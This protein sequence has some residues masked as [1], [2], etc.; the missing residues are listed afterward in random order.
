MCCVVHPGAVHL[1]GISAALRL[2]LGYILGMSR[3][4][5]GSISRLEGPDQTLHLRHVLDQPRLLH[6]RR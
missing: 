6:L 4:D 3:L 1:G 2:Y 5:L